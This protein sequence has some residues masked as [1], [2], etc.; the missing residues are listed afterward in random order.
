[1]NPPHLIGILNVTPDSFSDGNQFFTPESAL[2]QAQQ[3]IDDG[4]S[5]IDVGAESTRPNATPVS[6]AEEWERLAPILPALCALPVK[7]SLDSRHPETVVRALGLGVDIV[8][9]VSGLDNLAMREAVKNSSCQVVL[10]HHLGVPA[11]K[12]VTLPEG[13]DPVL[14]IIKWAHQR[15]ASC[16]IAKER[17]I[18]DP[19]LGF[20]KSAAQ[21]WEIVNRI[22]EFHALGL[23]LFVGHSR[24]SFLRTG[25]GSYP[26]S[27]AASRSLTLDSLPH[28]ACDKVNNYD[29]ETFD[30]SV[31]LA[32]AGVQYLRVHNV[33]GNRRAIEG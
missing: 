12:Q 7:I 4:A 27:P 11:N 3:L 33:A 13:C 28:I 1:M 9:D 5:I 17:L 15:I 20:G 23:P 21:S 6:A 8:N 26:Q 25:W 29:I 32:R 30:V 2:A 14:E 18:F 19:G 16:G 10:M 31:H 22:A 24:K